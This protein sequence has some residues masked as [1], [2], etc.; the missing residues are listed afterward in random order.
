MATP[1]TAL[2]VSDYMRKPEIMERF[3]ALLGKDAEP[4][5]QSVLIVVGSDDKLRDCT[6]QS[7]Y[8]T[9]LRAASLGLSC[10]PALKQGWIVPYNK[11]IAKK[12]EPKK[13][14]K[15][16]QFQPHYL[17]LRTLAMRTGKYWTIN[18]SEICEGQ[19]VLF[20]PLTGLHSVQ[21]DNGFVGQPKAANPAYIDVTERRRKN[22]KIIGWLAY[23]KAKNGEE[24]SVYMSCADIDDWA[25]MYVKDYQDNQN[26]Q[27]PDKRQTMEKKTVLRRLLD[28]TDKS[29]KD[30]QKLAE[31]M[32][33]DFEPEVIDAPAEDVP[34]VVTDLEPMNIDEARKVTGLV[35]G[36]GTQKQLGNCDPSELNYVY[37]N[38]IQPKTIEAARIILREDFRMDPPEAEKKSA[39][40]LQK[41]LGF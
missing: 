25:V 14:V 22:V 16:A 12:N 19:R 30:G 9:A 23:Y 37:L 36:K 35:D 10:D 8:K 15:E 1:T 39:D 31:A 4:F 26:W 7:I 20:N 21:E 34:G 17:G 13:W 24:K 41:E 11:N 33:E 40:Q 28:W 2:T 38:S 6:P 5:V 27:N 29:G 32:K 18:V 3:T